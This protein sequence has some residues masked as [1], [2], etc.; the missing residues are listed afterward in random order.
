VSEGAYDISGTSLLTL[1]PDDTLIPRP[2]GD[3]GQKGLRALMALG[4]FI[5]LAIYRRQPLPLS[6]SAV[7][8]KHLLG[9]PVG[10]EDVQQLDPEFWR[11]R[12]GQVLKPGG[13]EEIHEAL[14]EPLTFMSAP[15]EIRREPEELK[16][17]GCN[18]IVTQENKEEYL[19]LLCEDHLCGGIRQELQCMLQGFWDL[20]PLELLRR[21]QVSPRELSV[22]ISGVQE[23]DPCEWEKSSKVEGDEQVL[24]WFWEVV[25]DL[26]EVQRCM[27]LHFT[28]GSSRLQPGGFAD[29][30]PRFA[31]IVGPGDVEHLPHAHTCVNQLI[32]PV[33]R[34]KEQLRDKLL[35]ALTAQGFGFA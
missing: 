7:A 21:C 15:T 27:L 34:S 19:Q 29:L 22:M 12:V 9:V 8:C 16:P 11:G 4:K 35:P 26:N 5:A 18:F 3:K 6:F 23:L 30:K 32:M 2:V 13:L 10:M 28:T 25:R 17:D 20:L 31:V 33:Y 24:K 1:A 14:G